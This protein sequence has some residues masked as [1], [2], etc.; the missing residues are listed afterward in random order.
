MT[1]AEIYASA[2]YKRRIERNYAS[3]LAL[4]EGERLRNAAESMAYWSMRAGSTERPRMETSPAQRGKP[5]TCDTSCG[6]SIPCY[7]DGGGKLGELWDCQ[8]RAGREIAPP[9]DQ[10]P[11]GFTQAEWS[12]M[13]CAGRLHNTDTEFHTPDQPCP[14]PPLNRSPEH[15]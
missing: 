15:G 1:D 5:C 2:E 7:V 11:R 13:P 4:P 9:A 8:K 6:G 12:A 10:A 3:L 14:L